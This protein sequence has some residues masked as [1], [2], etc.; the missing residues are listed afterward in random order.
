MNRISMYLL[1]RIINP[2]INKSIWSNYPIVGIKTSNINML[3]YRPKSGGKN[4]GLSEEGRS[5]S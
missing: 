3:Q 1:I 2:R 4:G 5:A